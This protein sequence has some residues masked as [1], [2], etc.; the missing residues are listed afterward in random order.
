MEV[1]A[2]G[3]GGARTPSTWQRAS[4]HLWGNAQGAAIG[5]QRNQGWTQCLRMSHAVRLEVIVLPSKYEPRGYLI[6]L[7]C[8]SGKSC[9]RVISSNMCPRDL[10]PTARFLKHVLFAALCHLWLWKH[11]IHFVLFYFERCICL[12]LFSS[13]FLIRF[14]RLYGRNSWFQKGHREKQEVVFYRLASRVPLTDYMER[15]FYKLVYVLRFFFRL[16]TIKT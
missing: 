11:K 1:H 16:S 10:K 5:C 12:N 3:G 7:E 9:L 6:Q 14:L 8:L 15:S 13:L 4:V 2:R